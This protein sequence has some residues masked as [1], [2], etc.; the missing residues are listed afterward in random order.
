VAET[1]GLRGLAALALLASLAGATAVAAVVGLTTGIRAL[2]AA[3]GAGIVLVGTVT[4]ERD[5]SGVLDRDPARLSKVVVTL[6]L[7]GVSVAF[8]VDRTVSLLFF[9][10]ALLA[11]VG[12]VVGADSRPRLAAVSVTL[13][14]GLFSVSKFAGTRYYYGSGDV[15]GHTLGVRQLLREGPSAI[16]YTAY[17]SFPGLHVTA[18]GLHL[19]SGLPVYVAYTLVGTA[20]MTTVVAVVYLLYRLQFVDGRTAVVAAFLYATFEQT[21]FFSTYTFPQTLAFGFAVVVFYLGLSLTNDSNLGGYLL[22][23]LF[24]VA[25]ATTHHFTALLLFPA[26]GV[27]AVGQL[28]RGGLST[29]TVLKSRAA[30]VVTGWVGIVSLYWLVVDDWIFD[31]VA[32]TLRQNFLETSDT[33]RGGERIQTATEGSG[34]TNAVATATP[35]GASGQSQSTPSSATTT[36]ISDTGTQ[37]PDA[38]SGSTP[39]TAETPVTTPTGGEVDPGSIE[40]TLEAY[41]Y[42]TTGRLDTVERA[43]VSFAEPTLLYQ[44]ALVALVLFAVYALARSEYDVSFPSLLFLGTGA[45]ALMLQTP[46]QIWSMRRLQMV[47]VVFFVGFAAVGVSWA[48]RQRET[49][50]SV[51][52]VLVVGLAAVSGGLGAADDVSAVE[53][54]DD[55]T[56][57]VALGD[58]YN[59][60]TELASF[61]DRRD[62]N[63]SA[64]WIADGSLRSF[65]ASASQPQFGERVVVAEGRLLLVES[66]WSERMFKARYESGIGL[67]R[68]YFSEE[69]LDRLQSDQSRVYTSGDVALL[70]DDDQV[71]R[72]VPPANRTAGG[73]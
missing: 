10:P 72:V 23:G 51:A 16:T 61:V 50:T 57:A 33:G 36:P 4:V 62:A 25:S 46:I 11:L 60:Y 19:V 29:A 56:R 42:G 18:A 65:G 30:Q 69:S 59:Q 70:Y 8:L 12:V 7:L 6:G 20:V 37:T 28:L 73:A 49:A 64:P 58:D 41:T 17:A 55:Q 38:T 40:T 22:A 21:V 5:L 63:V 35:A 71:Y 52:V 34:G 39:G 26:A 1:I 66:D 32:Y 14:Y 13:L 15:L 2:Y 45:T 24:A 3:V 54:T 47:W 53:L 9:L 68:V 31:A 27:I 44:V 43:L 48:L 67:A